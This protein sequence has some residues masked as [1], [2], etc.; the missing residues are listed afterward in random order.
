MKKKEIF[1]GFALFLLIIFLFDTIL[2]FFILPWNQLTFVWISWKGDIDFMTMGVIN[3]F[4]RLLIYGLMLFSL[5]RFVKV[6]IPSLLL[7]I[8]PTVYLMIDS[9]WVFENY[10]FLYGYW[11]SLLL[12][13]GLIIWA[14]VK[15]VYHPRMLMMI[16]GL[17]LVLGMLIGLVYV[18]IMGWNW[19]Y[20]FV[21]SFFQRLVYESLFIFLVYLGNLLHQTKE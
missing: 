9:W 18:D 15:K 11:S 17:S 19:P 14:V 4:A 13:I 5:R 1:Q 2:H 21:Y 12:V 3:I 7:V 20:E 16:A 8:I 6:S 10:L